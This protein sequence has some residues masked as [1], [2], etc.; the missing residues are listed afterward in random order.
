MN[1]TVIQ[2]VQ[3]PTAPNARA[4]TL[5]EVVPLPNRRQLENRQSPATPARFTNEAGI[6]ITDLETA[7]WCKR[8]GWHVLTSNQ[9]SFIG[10]IIITLHERPLTDA[11][12][13]W[14]AG[15]VSKINRQVFGGD[16]A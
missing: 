5:G 9:R 16:A 14:L 13:D 2:F 3:R 15:L 6:P 12:A 11:Q 1:A 4:V 7:E 10:T 8:V